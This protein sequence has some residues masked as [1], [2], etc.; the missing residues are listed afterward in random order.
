M[1]YTDRFGDFFLK[2]CTRRPVILDARKKTAD[3][4]GSRCFIFRANRENYRFSAK[5]LKFQKFASWGK[6]CH[7][8]FQENFKFFSGASHFQIRSILDA[9]RIEVA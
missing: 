7:A 9:G 1:P 2:K 5:F 6:K 3:F 4:P 8:F